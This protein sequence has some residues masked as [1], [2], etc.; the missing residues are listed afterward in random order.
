MRHVERNNAK[1]VVRFVQ[2]HH[3]VRLLYDLQRIRLHRRSGHARRHAERALPEIVRVFH[4][5]I[6]VRARLQHRICPHA[7]PESSDV[8][9]REVRMPIHL[10]NRFGRAALVP[11]LG[12]NRRGAGHH[13]GHRCLARAAAS[14]RS[15]RVGGRRLGRDHLH[16]ASRH[17]SNA[18]V[19][20]R[21]VR[22]H[23]RPSEPRRL[24]RQDRSGRRRETIDV[25]RRAHWKSRWSWSGFSVLRGGGRRYERYQQCQRG[26]TKPFFLEEHACSAAPDTRSDAEGYSAAQ[27]VARL[28]GGR[29]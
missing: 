16:S 7:D 6:L 15:E 25:P 2:N 19:H 8:D 18:L 12:R 29:Q 20:V 21:V 4:D 28:C 24:P 3:K 5:A 13:H 26:R 11:F 9:A 1:Q 10:R 23:G 17:D 14:G 22:I 27:Y